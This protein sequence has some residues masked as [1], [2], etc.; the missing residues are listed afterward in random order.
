M[1][2]RPQYPYS[3]DT[4]T[5]W[6]LMP[7]NENEVVVYEN[8]HIKWEFTRRPTSLPDGSLDPYSW[9]EHKIHMSIDGGHSWKSSDRFNELYYNHFSEHMWNFEG[10][11]PGVKTRLA[12]IFSAR[13][14]WKRNRAK[15]LKKLSAARPQEE[16]D[17]SAAKRQEQRAASE[18]LRQKKAE[19]QQVAA[20]ED[21]L[22]LGPNLVKLK[23][24]V[25]SL[26]ALMVKGGIDRPPIQYAAKEQNL[27][28]T[29]WTLGQLELHFKKCQERT[30][31]SGGPRF[32]KN[33]F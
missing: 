2:H 32:L 22:S 33:K 6:C 19:D 13:E 30:G 3:I 10:R 28:E 27:R 23:D 9:P 8:I 15:E 12:P 20:L 4:E 31:K 16:K 11:S 29:I 25:D 21:L 24:K 17:R 26:I 18:A 14:A 1:P 5:G 7:A